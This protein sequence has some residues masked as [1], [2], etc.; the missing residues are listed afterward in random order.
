MLLLATF[1]EMITASTGRETTAVSNHSLDRSLL[2]LTRYDPWSIRASFTHLLALGTT[3]SGKTSGTLK[4]VILAMLNAGF[5][6]LFCI[7][8]SE[9]A[10]AIVEYCRQTKRLGSLL[11]WNGT[12]GG[13]NFLAGELAR[14]GNINNVIDLLMAVLAMV[15]ETGSNAGRA[16]E[17]FWIDSVLQQL[18]A[19]V[20]IIFAATGTVR[21]SDILAFV[22]SAPNSL[23]QMRDPTWQ[24]DSF[25]FSIFQAAAEVLDD[26]SGER[27]MAY[28]REFCSLDAKTAG[29]IRVSLTTALSRF[30]H[31]WLKEAFCG[32][33]TLCPELMMSGGVLILMDFPV[34][35]HGEDAALGQKIFK[36]CSQRVLLARNG[37]EPHLRDRPVAIVADECQNF[38]YNDAEFLAQCRSSMVAVVMA[39][40]SLPTL[41]A[42]I[43]GDH[44]HDRAHHLISNFNNIV[45]HSTACPETA[46]WFARKIGKSVQRRANFSESE[47]TNQSFG[48]TMG[49]GSNWNRRARTGVIGMGGGFGSGDDPLWHREPG[50]EGGS[51]NWGRN[52]GQGH[53]SNTSHGYSE[54]VDWIIEPSFL[55][56]GL[57]TGG[58]ANR[59]RV[60]AVWY[61]AGRRFSSG[62]NA[63][64]AEFRQ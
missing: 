54:T 5:G 28:W 3:G 21:I 15:R 39:T 52:R 7:A 64:L 17:Q 25:F 57:M 37:M 56:R 1:T 26:A 41:Y 18:R 33:T 63:L 46:E 34:Q 36:Y 43:G 35:T 32:E 49:E 23:E 59:N 16:S 51:D 53:N 48:M 24:R 47:G 50:S 44:P 8:K 20:P 60:S 38:L 14:S 19:T 62:G 4:H 12:N 6:A 58:P 22:R 11:H 45:L 13:Y 9:D 2:N 55:A 30:E 10:Q 31:G 40:Q 42:K 61:Q 29:N 27:A